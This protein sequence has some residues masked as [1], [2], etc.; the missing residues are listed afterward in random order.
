MTGAHQFLANLV[1]I[2]T[3]TTLFYVAVNDL[4][5]FKIR[6]EIVITLACL[7]GIYAFLPGEWVDAWRNVALAVFMFV[8]LLIFYARGWLGGGDVKILTVGFLWV[9]DR[10][11]MPF[12]IFLLIF[13]C[14]HVLAARLG[15]VRVRYA[16]GT[17]LLAF[18][19]AVAGALIGV[20]ALKWSGY[21]IL[22]P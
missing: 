4:R 6:N 5:E 19:P 14:I 9:G 21:W 10:Y 2:I 15:W 1:L 18:A 20:F 3:A 7:Y 11:A 22:Q 8:F 13:A 16:G 12:S 17:T